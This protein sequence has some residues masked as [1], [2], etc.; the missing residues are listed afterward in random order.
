MAPVAGSRKNNHGVTV[1]ALQERPYDMED[2]DLDLDLGQ[3]DLAASERLK[4]LFLAAASHA[5]SHDDDASENFLAGLASL[6]D[7]IQRTQWPRKSDS[8][9]ML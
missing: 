9:N 8:S 4:D 2:L 5:R 6:M 3:L 7:T 1:L